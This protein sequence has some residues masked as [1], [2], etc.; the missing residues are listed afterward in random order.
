MS[1]EGEAFVPMQTARRALDWPTLGVAV[2]LLLLFY[3][4]TGEFAVHERQ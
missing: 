1:R 3:W 2:L 4:G